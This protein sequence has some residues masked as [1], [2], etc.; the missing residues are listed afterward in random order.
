MCV[1]DLYEVYRTSQ[2]STSE[3]NA[4]KTSAPTYTHFIFHFT[5]DDC[6]KGQ[7]S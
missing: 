6:M 4:L 7:N 5:V 2:F 3:N 1:T